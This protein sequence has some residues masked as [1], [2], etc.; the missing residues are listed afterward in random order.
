MQ[1]HNYKYMCSGF[2][3]YLWSDLSEFMA[4]FMIFHWLIGPGFI[5]EPYS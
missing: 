3:L 1:V 5:F 4:V 2:V